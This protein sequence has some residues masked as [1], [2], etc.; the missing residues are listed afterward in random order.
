VPSAYEVDEMPTTQAALLILVLAVLPGIPGNAVYRVLVGVSW[1]E[2]QWETVLR[3]IGLSAMGLVLYVIAAQLLHLPPARHV[4][5]SSY[6]ATALG[7]E[8]LSS[9]VA[10]YLGHFVGSVAAGTAAAFSEWGI[11]R[12]ARVTRYPDAWWAFVNQHVPRSWVVLALDNGDSLV[13]V[14]ANADV[15]VP[16]EQRDIV[17]KEPGRYDEKSKNYLALR[18]QYLF[19]P[20]E[21]IA[22]IAV[23]YNPEVHGARLTAVGEAMFS[24]QEAPHA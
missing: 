23:Q 11:N 5:P 15:D 10:P 19:I 14:V 8:T 13:G 12:A 7:P 9:L 17:L 22:S 21:R 2:P 18:Y 20:G 24:R 4:F 16:R 1:R 3:L 6:A